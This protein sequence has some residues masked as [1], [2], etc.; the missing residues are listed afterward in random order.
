MHTQINYLMKLAVEY[1][2]RSD[3]SG[4]ER[5]LKQALRLS[6]KNSEA[7]RL[8]GISFAF[9]KDLQDALQMFDKSIKVDPANWLAHSNRGNV[10][11]ELNEF[12]ASL[13][14]YE[15]AIL[16][17]PKY[18]EAHNNRGNIL[19][20]LKRF[21]EAIASYEEAI[22]LQPNYVDAY[23]NLGNALKKL[24]YYD[25]AL[26]AYERGMEC[27]VPNKL[28][29]GAYINCKMQLC[30]WRDLE[31]PLKILKNILNEPGTNKF[32][33]FYL[34]P[35]SD[36]PYLIKGITYEYMCSEYPIKTELGKLSAPQNNKKI[37]LGY[38]SPDFR[39]HAVSFLIAGVI[40]AHDKSKF[41]IIAFSMGRSSSDDMT[42]R[43]RSSFDDFVDISLKSDI[44]AAK[45]VRDLK[46]DIAIDLGGLT[47]DARPSIFAYRA[48]PIQ[49]GYIGYLST[50]AAPYY[51][52]IVAD[53]VVIPKELQDAYSEKIIYLPSYQA[54]D[55]KREIADRDFTREELG[56]PSSGFVY[57]CFNN[58]YKI[59]PAILD[60]WATI[61]L[62][63]E[64]SVIFLYAENATVRKNLLAE[65]AIRDIHQDRIIFAERL[66]RE[67]YLARYRSAGLFLDT[68]PYN[69]GT[70]ASDALWAG[71][72]V[73]SF[74]GKSFS[75]R[76]G[77]SILN[78]IGLPEL[79]GKSQQ[80]YKSIA[81]DLGKNPNKLQEIKKKLNKNR[82]TTPLFD[83][84]L[85][86]RNLELA[87][88]RA[89]ARNRDGLPP[90]NI[91]L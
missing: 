52:Y 88:E 83:T 81:I 28:L 21:D 82:L 45:I 39:N 86:T 65:F 70:T 84:K 1:I 35:V 30:D 49:I 29:L 46:I 5:L 26:I 50:M 53:E 9:K 91:N 15:K 6:P 61:L 24:S 23:N 36:D 76:M 56:L 11:R 71:L 31:G 47:Q 90:E 62:A 80:E 19:Q 64:A 77:A 60:S 66:P 12:D 68:S 40:E 7:L 79:V 51:D 78:A 20:D 41:E 13:K 59:T 18:S 34:L 14:S 48:A 2:Q 16:L 3:F 63:V 38:F 8:L 54:N 27:G 22:A 10:L 69:A 33:P 44:D 58:N 42:D 4:A 25:L 57:C 87:Y 73:V 85:F 67:E 43:L 75:A 17:Q 37:R 32:I 74:A 55:P 89:Y 72:P